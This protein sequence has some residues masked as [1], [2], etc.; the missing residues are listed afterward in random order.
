MMKI[1]NRILKL[2]PISNQDS[3]TSTEGMFY[4]LGKLKLFLDHTIRFSLLFG[5]LFP[6]K[7]SSGHYRNQIN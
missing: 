6:R 7:K 1:Y 4:S 3:V 5:G 2:S